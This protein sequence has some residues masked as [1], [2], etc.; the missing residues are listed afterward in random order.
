VL[1]SVIGY[2]AFR[3]G[4]NFWVFFILSLL[5]S[6]ILGGLILAIYDYYKVFMKGRI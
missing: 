5:L 4:H 2:F 6:P 3:L 1:S